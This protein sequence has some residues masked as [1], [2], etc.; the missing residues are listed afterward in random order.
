[1]LFEIH[2]HTHIYNNTHKH[3]LTKSGR[4]NS[5]PAVYCS[6]DSLA[7]QLHC[8]RA[9]CLPAARH[10]LA[11][12]ARLHSAISFICTLIFLLT[13]T[14]HTF[15]TVFHSSDRS[16]ASE[17]CYFTPMRFIPLHGAAT[18]YRVLA[19]WPLDIFNFSVLHSSFLLLFTD[20]LFFAAQY[21]V[22]PL[23]LTRHSLN[24]Q[25]TLYEFSCG[26]RL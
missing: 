18:M 14:Q 7:T 26:H 13:A 16:G 19:G 17:L 2:T 23:L 10:V 6:T 8:R 3:K 24:L 12:H 9:Y 21:Y 11:C 1:M 20:F 25:Q 15:V 5:V 4:K 22:P